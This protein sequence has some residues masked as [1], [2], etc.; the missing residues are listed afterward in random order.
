MDTIPHADILRNCFL[1]YALSQKRIYDIY[2][3]PGGGGGRDFAVAL[4][5]DFLMKLPI[6]E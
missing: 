3:V 2:C 4:F 5:A 1:Q 6:H